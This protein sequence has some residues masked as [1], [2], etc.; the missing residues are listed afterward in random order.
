MG[1]FSRKFLLTDAYYSNNCSSSCNC[2]TLRTSFVSRGKKLVFVV[3]AGKKN[4]KAFRPHLSDCYV[5]SARSTIK[6]GER[7][8]TLW[9]VC[10]YRVD[11][12]KLAI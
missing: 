7:D 3:A 11:G 6:K 5:K 9:C 8:P 2:H 1:R 4:P 10:F 12:P